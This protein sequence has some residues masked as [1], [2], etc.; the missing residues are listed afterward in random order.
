MPG[1]GP[2]CVINEGTLCDIRG[3]GV[4]FVLGGEGFQKLSQC[5]V[6]YQ[7]QE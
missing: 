4:S 2:A 5:G 1:F 6:T 3:P 7:S